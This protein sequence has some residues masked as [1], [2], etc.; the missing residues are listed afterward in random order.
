MSALLWWFGQNTIAIAVLILFVAAACRLFRYRPAVQH[1]LWVVVLLKFVTP[2][3]VCWPWSV[4]QLGQLLRSVAAFEKASACFTSVLRPGITL[5]SVSDEADDDR[6]AGNASVPLRSLSS[7]PVGLDERP[8]EGG[9][10]RAQIA[11]VPL[12]LVMCI[13]LVGAA[14]CAMRQLRRVARHASLVGRGTKAPVQLTNE[15]EAIA[16]QL[17]LKHPQSLIARGITS[18]FVWF[19]GRLRLVWPESMSGRDAIVRSRGVIAHEL[20]HV[21]RG[22]H[23]VA[24]LEL[25]AGIVWW[26][27]PLLWFVRRRLRASAEMACDAIALSLCPDDRR[28]YAELLLELSA[29]LKTG[30]LAPVLGVSAS[31]PS[32]LERRLSMILSDRVVGKVSVSGYVIAGFLCLVAL[33]GWSWAQQ[34]PKQEVGFQEAMVVYGP[35]TEAASRGTPPVASSGAPESALQSEEVAKQTAAR[36]EKLEAEL[37]KLSQLVEQSHRPAVVRKGDLPARVSAEAVIRADNATTPIVIKGI[38]RTYVISGV[39]KR[40]FITALTN[41]GR[42]IWVSS[43]PAPAPIRGSGVTWTLDEAMNMPAVIL[44]WMRD[45][46]SVVFRFHRNTGQVLTAKQAEEMINSGA[47]AAEIGPGGLGAKDSPRRA[48]VQLAPTTTVPAQLA[49]PTTVPAQLAPPTT[50]PAQLDPNRAPVEQLDAARSVPA[51]VYADRNSNITAIPQEAGVWRAAKITRMAKANARAD[52]SERRLRALEQ[53]VEDLR[54][55]LEP[56]ASAGGS[57]SDR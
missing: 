48:A 1:V 9:T 5:S 51:E 57:S 30:V 46:E 31:A 29:G 18:P 55:R 8:A 56:S 54:R 3:I 40:A 37:R 49:P 4:Q 36:L 14:I 6:A 44:I 16:R 21:R 12:D 11:R 47:Y 42:E 45:N 23:W 20:A 13:W 17:R 35:S 2:P 52:S 25:L 38:E 34:H 39:Q 50:V 43:F 33:P 22:D 28:T 15:V 27:N 53:A 32:S 24:W 7:E 10:S 26:W 19:M 41:E